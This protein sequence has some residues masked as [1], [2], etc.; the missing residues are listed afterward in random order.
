MEKNWE[1]TLPFFYINRDI[2][3]NL[4]KD[5]VDKKD[6]LTIK[7]VDEGCRTSNYIVDTSNGTKYILKIFFSDEQ[8][9]KKECE[10]LNIL[11]EKVP[12]QEIY[13]FDKDSLIENKYYA[14]YK[15]IEGTTLSKSLDENHIINSAIIEDAASALA[16]I[17]SFK[18]NEV[19]FLDENLNTADKLAPLD[20]WYEKI[21]NK[22]V[23][24]RLGSELTRKVRILI[25]KKCSELAELDKDPRLVHGDFQGTNILIKENKISGIIDW[26]FSMA[27]HPLA[28]IGQFFR[29]DEYFN[30]ESLLIFEEE[31]RK[32]SDYILPENWYELSRIRDMANLIQLLGF[33]EEMPNKY[34]EIKMRI[35]KIIDEYKI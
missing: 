27:G 15:F 14:I 35:T 13:K 20:K 25:D 26:E 10:I 18:F 8:Y 1:R 28:D 24:K 30:D 31:Y 23:E 19:G 21:I 7:P 32:K 6:I 11:K 2:V 5:L 29:Y 34:Q 4:F 16:E 33:E 9:Y 12:V 3:Y 17:H 22:R